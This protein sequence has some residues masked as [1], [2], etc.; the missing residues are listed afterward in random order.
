VSSCCIRIACGGREVA[1][2]CRV[3]LCQGRGGYVAPCW[4]APREGH[5]DATRAGIASGGE[6]GDLHNVGITDGREREG[7]ALM[8]NRSRLN[9]LQLEM[10]GGSKDEEGQ[11]NMEKPH[12]F[13]ST[14]FGFYGKNTELE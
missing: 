12:L 10:R 1:T 8:C 4:I 7:V 3:G 14:I 9:R 2:P 13:F 6:R 5:V 11:E